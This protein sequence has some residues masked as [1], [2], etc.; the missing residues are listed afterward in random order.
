MHVSENS[1]YQEKYF[2][3]VKKRVDSSGRCREGLWLNT[4][5]SRPAHLSMT[6]QDTGGQM[7]LIEALV[8]PNAAEV[9]FDPPRVK[10][11]HRPADLP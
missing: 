4:D 5:S 2:Y 9:D 1:L 7:T 11:L 8:Q 3:E 6:I 10:D